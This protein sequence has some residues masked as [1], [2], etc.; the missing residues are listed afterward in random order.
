[1]HSLPF[2]KQ[3]DPVLL[4]RERDDKDREDDNEDEAP[5]EEKKQKREKKNEIENK[6]NQMGRSKTNHP[7]PHPHLV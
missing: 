7:R 2:E 4:H 6:M 1:M 3:V 5:T